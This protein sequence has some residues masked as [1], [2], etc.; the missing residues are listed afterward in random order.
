[1]LVCLVMYIEYGLLCSSRVDGI[2]ELCKWVHSEQ[3]VLESLSVADSKLK[4][5]TASLL[6][7]LAA[8]RSLKKLD[9]RYE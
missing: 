5:Y 7:S 9:I 2:K 3:C 1:M 8:N 6:H 4:E